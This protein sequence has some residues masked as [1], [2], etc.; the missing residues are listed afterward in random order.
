MRWVHRVTLTAF[1]KPEE[2][3]EAIREGIKALVPFNLEN[4]KLSLQMQNAEGF[5]ERI[6]KIFTI[7]LTKEK[8]TNDFLQFLLDSLNEEQK[9]M[10][11]SQA[12]SRL[13]AEYD[14]FIRI[15]K[16]EWIQERKIELTDTGNCFHIKMSLAVFPKKKETALQLVQK[17]FAQKNI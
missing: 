6:I 16:N 3:V 7:V 10:L 12:E 2:N 1:A 17:M 4:E 9:K 13:D 5:E 14:F 11:I 15:D 8:H